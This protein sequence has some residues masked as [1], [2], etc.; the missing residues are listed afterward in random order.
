MGVDLQPPRK[1]WWPSVS[2]IAFLM[3]YNAPSRSR[4]STF[5][6]TPCVILDD[7]AARSKC[8]ELVDRGA[9]I[10]ASADVDLYGDLWYVGGDR[11]PHWPKP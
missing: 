7:K 1:S 3:Q 8:L 5:S 2:L 10:V 4:E 6:W 9:V 11:P